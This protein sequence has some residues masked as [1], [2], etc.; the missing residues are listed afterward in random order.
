MSEVAANTNVSVAVTKGMAARQCCVYL[1][2]DG[3]NLTFLL[4]QISHLCMLLANYSQLKEKPL[5][6]LDEGS[7]SSMAA[8][9]LGGLSGDAPPVTEAPL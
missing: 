1:D 6:K 2:L 9:L 3:A 8:G 7:M 5:Q 4:L